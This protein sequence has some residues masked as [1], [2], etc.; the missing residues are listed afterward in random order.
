MRPWQYGQLGAC[1]ATAW[2]LWEGATPYPSGM[3]HTAIF[4]AVVG[5]DV[6]G[7]FGNIPG[8]VTMHR[9]LGVCA[10]VSLSIACHSANARVGQFHCF[11]FQV[12]AFT[13]SGSYHFQTGRDSP[14]SYEY[15]QIHRFSGLR[16]C[17]I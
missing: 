7:P 6:P 4:P 14:Y 1:M 16:E 3:L 9:M 12:D 15:S 17:F 13:V 11:K 5:A 2:N 8:D 10:S